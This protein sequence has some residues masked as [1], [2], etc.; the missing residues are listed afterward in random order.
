MEEYQNG[1]LQGNP[2]AAARRVQ[3]AGNRTK[4]AHIQEKD[5]RISGCGIT[6]PLEEAVTNKQPEAS[7]FPE[8]YALT[9]TYLEPDYTWIHSELAMRGVTLSIYAYVTG[10]ITPAY[11]FT[12]LRLMKPMNLYG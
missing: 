10:G 2:A 12:Y 1:K 5:P 3:P 9:S 4:P 7:L 8:R 11:L 6:W